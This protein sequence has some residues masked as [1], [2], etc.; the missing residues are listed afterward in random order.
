M[1]LMLAKLLALVT[2]LLVLALS[3]VFAWVQ[4]L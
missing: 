1:R 3:A 2:G 4:N